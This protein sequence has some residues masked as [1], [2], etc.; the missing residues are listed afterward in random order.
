[1]T[2]QVVLINEYLTPTKILHHTHFSQKKKNKIKI[3]K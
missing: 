1:M 3:N 2:D